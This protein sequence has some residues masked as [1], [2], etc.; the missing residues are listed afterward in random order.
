MAITGTAALYLLVG[1]VLYGGVLAF[2]GLNH[3][4]NADQMEGY[5]EHKGVP[6]P[7]LAVLGSGA[8]LALGGILIVLGTYAG[9]GAILAAAFFLVVTPQIHNFW[10]VP[11]DQKQD[12]MNHFLKNVVMLGA[13]LAILAISTQSWGLAV[14]GGVF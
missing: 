6:A 5:A 1:R 8:V 3:F 4:M 14:G 13:A 12:E 7:R 10:A 9:L 2:M 11:E